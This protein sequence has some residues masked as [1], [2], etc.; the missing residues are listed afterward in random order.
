MALMRQAV[1]GHLGDCLHFD[2]TAM[3]LGRK[4]SVKCC[5]Y[6]SSCLHL[7]LWADCLPILARLGVTTI[8]SHN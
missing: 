8:P 7:F 2:A 3:V 4:A 5:M 6:V 1:I